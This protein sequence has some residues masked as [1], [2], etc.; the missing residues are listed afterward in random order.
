MCFAVDLCQGREAPVHIQ[1]SQPVNDIIGSE[2]LHRFTSRQWSIHFN[3]V[4]VF[5][6]TVTRRAKK[7]FWNGLNM[8]LPLDVMMDIT[9]DVD[10]QLIF[11]DDD[12]Y[13]QLRFSGNAALNYRV[14]AMY[15]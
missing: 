4:S 3:I 15:Y 2:Y 9:A 7:M 11:A 5:S 10:A 14:S 12:L 6:Q 1:I 8:I 13:M